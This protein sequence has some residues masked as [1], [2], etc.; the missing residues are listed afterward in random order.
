MI[1]KYK[2]DN[3]SCNY[4]H[5]CDTIPVTGLLG[6]GCSA[7]LVETRTVVNTLVVETSR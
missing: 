7:V 6:N 5:Y 4:A 2:I 1:L 3:L